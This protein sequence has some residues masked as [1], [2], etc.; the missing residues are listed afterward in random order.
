VLAGLGALATATTALAGAG[1]VTTTVERLQTAV[2]YS[3]GADPATKPPTP[4]LTT[5][6][7]YLVT[8]TNAGGNTIN[9]IRFT[10]RA[11]VTDLAETAK[12]SS[13]EGASCQATSLPNEVSCTIGQLTAGQAFPA[14]ALF[15]EAPVKVSQNPA[16]PDDAAGGD[17]VSLS[18]TTYYAEGTGGANSVP[19]NS[20]RTWG[21]AGPV[22]LGTDNPTLVQSGVPK[23]G[24]TFFTGVGG[25]SNGTDKLTTSVKVPAAASY[26]KATIDEGATCVGDANFFYACYQ[27]QLT[28]LDGDGSTASFPAPYLTITLRQDASNIK[29]GTK[30][31]SVKI[32]YGSNPD[33]PLSDLIEVGDCATGPVPNGDGTPCIAKRIYYKNSSVPGWAPDLDEDF[34]WQLLNDRNGTYRFPG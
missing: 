20:K 34:E 33:A 18:G 23:A 22:T 4:A 7:G 1:D 8:V 24:G 13:A 21:P 26:S 14:V 10:A 5:F 19:Q 9:N 12:F 11:A 16:A 32:Y 29:P 6:V 27:S 28:I 2:T 31:G 30:I 17:Q 25:V 3:K 15:F